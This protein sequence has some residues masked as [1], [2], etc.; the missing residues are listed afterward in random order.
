MQTSD[1]KCECFFFV[2]LGQGRGTRVGGGSGGSLPPQLWSRGRGVPTIFHR[3][4][5]R[6]AAVVVPKLGAVGHKGKLNGRKHLSEK[7]TSFI[8]T[9]AH[10]ADKPLFEAATMV[11]FA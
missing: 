4:R 3:A 9:A 7:F 1:Y 5:N 10:L 6:V 2:S 8:G 11:L